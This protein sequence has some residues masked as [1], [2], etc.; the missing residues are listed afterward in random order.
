MY[1]HRRFIIKV[2]TKSAFFVFFRM[3]K[4][5]SHKK[6]ALHKNWLLCF[7]CSKHL[8]ISHLNDWRNRDGTFY[9]IF[10][11]FISQTN[12]M[13]SVQHD[14]CHIHGQYV[15]RLV[16]I[17]ADDNVNYNIIKLHEVIPTW[18]YTHVVQLSTLA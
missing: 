5:K 1:A 17:F 18:W 16:P 13:T 4:K 10:F 7:K 3:V 8:L 6:N 9:F 12:Y 15:C 14:D 2:R 11:L